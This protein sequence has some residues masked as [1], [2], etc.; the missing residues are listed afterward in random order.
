MIRRPPRSTRTYTRLP[1]PTLFRSSVH[2]CTIA[3][4]AGA[5]VVFDIDYR[6]VL[7]GL[8][9]KDM[10]ENRFVADAAVTARPQ[11]V[12]PLCD[13]VVGTE[14]EVH[15]LGGSPDAFAALRATRERTPRSEGQRRGEEV[16]IPW[17]YR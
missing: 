11:Q 17:R 9:G 5:T 3:R 8:A 4:E 16:A 2:A 12:L 1:S 6:P 7:W 13:L 15:I 14:E 10:G